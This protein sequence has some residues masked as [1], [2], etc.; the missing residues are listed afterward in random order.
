MAR[1]TAI[2]FA[3]SLS[4]AAYAIADSPRQI[5][6]PAG[7]L[8]QALESLARQADVS[9]VYQAQQLA[10]IRTRGVSG[11]LTAQDAVAKLLEGTKLHLRTDATS[12]AMLIEGPT[13]SGSPRASL[14]SAI[15]DPAQEG[16]KSSSD[17]FRVAQVDQGSSNSVG[18]A[19]QGASS[20][21]EGMAQLQEV[22][23]TAQKKTERAL[24]VPIAMTV[25]NPEELA[26]NGQGRLVDYFGTVPGLNVEPN[27]FLSG[28]MYL[29]IRGLSA[30]I[31]Q[32]ATVA[33]VVDDVPIGTGS[34][35][36]Y[37]NLAPPDID[38]SDLARIEVL[39]G[40]QGTLYG[41]DSLG[42]LIKY[43]TVDPSTSALTGRIEVSGVDVPVGGAGYSVRAAANIPLSDA[44]AVRVSGFSRRDPGYVN[45]LISGETNVNSVDVSGGRISAMWR[46][47]GDFSLKL[48]AI[49]QKTN[50]NGSAYFNAQLSGPSACPGN[51]ACTG[52]LQPTNG[53]LNFTGEPFANPYSTQQ[54]LYTA[55]VRAKVAGLDLVSVTG[56]N[57]STLN[58]RQD[59]GPAFNTLFLS[60]ENLNVQGSGVL[61][62]NTIDKFTQELRL[63]SSI[64]QWFDWLVGGFYTREVAPRNEN[65]ADNYFVDPST[66]A[67]GGLL[68]TY[69]W[70]Y[71]P[72][73][74]SEE[75]VF[76]DV[77]LH[78]TDRFSLQVGGREARNRIF[79]QQENTGPGIIDLFGVPSPQ[80]L[81]P[82]R[83]SGNAFT[84]LVSPQFKLSSDA[85]VY[86]RIASGYRIGGPNPI[87][88]AQS[89]DLI[90]SDY[91]P[92]RTNNYEM[93]LKGE[94]LDKRLS[95]DAAIYY[96]TWHD[97]Q[98]NVNY[99]PV[100]YFVTNAGNAK[101]E[102]VEFAIQARPLTGLTVTVQGSYNDAALT[103][104]PPAAARAAGSYAAAGDRMPYSIR[105]SGGVTANQDARLSSDWTGFLGG[106]LTYV[107]LREGEFSSYCIPDYC[108]P[109]GAIAP[110]AVLPG[111]A[112]INLHTGVRNESWLFNLYL[113]NLAD[114]RGIVG[115]TPGTAAV[116]VTGGY[117]GT[118]IQPRAIG[119]SVSRTF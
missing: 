115:A 47:S 32:N 41:A 16:T 75:A 28:T 53:Y 90:P 112:T 96:T 13:T 114:R 10:G 34:V 63:S 91:K 46:P 38:P 56:Y 14:R 40:P 95:I 11:N 23:V 76:G 93:G 18:P 62:R 52:T 21:S 49:I 111:Y 30:G 55:T 48:G 8:V 20:N 106:A 92:D 50:A 107:G 101:S 37:G 4:V 73:T 104:N 12:G 29:T 67:V 68:W 102:G 54:Q 82:E 19:A 85:M 9:L 39:K 36:E 78:F 118:V 66:G 70:A 59:Y 26:Q 17:A 65:R 89:A 83:A 116:G 80:V 24:D 71:S 103:D 88:S 86:A 22:I 31:N 81:A 25:L 87:P 99:G 100:D 7:D 98:L 77:T 109:N 6:V 94:F 57:V 97:F 69:N 2:A 51:S 35:L 64:G 110:R 5:N 117:Y 74:L 105:W 15:T 3:C 1:L 84:Y 42:G 108:P 60:P 44:I 72:F 27:A 113:N 79:F 45:D 119:V 61:Q 43:V 33:T 58:A